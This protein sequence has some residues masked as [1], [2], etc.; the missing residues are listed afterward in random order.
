MLRDTLAAILTDRSPLAWESEHLGHLAECVGAA[1]QLTQG[2]S[3]HLVIG[4]PT[5]RWWLAVAVDEPTLLLSGEGSA[6]AWG[7]VPYGVP[8]EAA[9]VRQ[10]QL[11]HQSGQH[12]TL[13]GP[14]EAKETGRLHLTPSQGGE[15]AGASWAIWPRAPLLT[16]ERLKGAGAAT[17]LFT[18]AAL[19]MVGAGQG[20]VGAVFFGRSR[21]SARALT[22]FLQR[23][24]RAGVIW[25][26]A[27]SLPATELG[28]GALHLRAAG[29]PGA[30]DLDQ[31]LGQPPARF[32][33]RERLPGWVLEIRRAGWAEYGLGIAAT[34]LGAETET[35]HL[36]DGED[37]CRILAALGQPG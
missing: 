36:A 1:G 10:R 23:E 29:A 18:A 9:L 35:V 27:V 5:A 14:A 3:P 20:G 34:D 24:P 2:G 31:R 30:A 22:P 25:L 32:L 11:I 17:R 13:D 16:R 21:L 6:T 7:F 19:A 26:A 15:P 37:L 33:E 4:E 12:V 8:T 28:S